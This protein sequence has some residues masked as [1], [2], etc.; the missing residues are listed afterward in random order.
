MED[1]F[2]AASDKIHRIWE[3]SLTGLYLR[4]IGA[5]VVGLFSIMLLNF[6]TP[7]HLLVLH[8]NFILREGG[9]VLLV[10]IEPIVMGI[11]ILFQY[12]IQRPVVEVIKA[13]GR[14]EEV[15]EQNLSRVRRRILNLPFIFWFFNLAL[16]IVLSLILLSLFALLL[17]A[18]AKQTLLL[19]FRT[20]MIG[21]IAANLSFFLVEDHTRRILIPVF[22]PKG[23]LHQVPGILRISILRR[24]RMLYM[25]GTSVPMIILLGTLFFTIWD[26]GDSSNARL[27]GREILVF[28]FVLCA[29]FFI[30]A[31][32]LN[33]LVERSILEPLKA[34]LGIIENLESGDFNQKIRVTS[35]DEIGILGD[36]GNRMISGLA[37]RERIRETFGKYVTPEIRD[38]ILDGRIPLDGER[39]EATLLFSDLRD[40]TTY[41]EENA[42]EEVIRSMREYFTAMQKAIR[43]HQGLVLQ[44]VGDEIEAAFGIPIHISDHAE[45]ALRAAIA[46]RKSLE[47]LNG[48]RE[49]Q[50]K[51]PFKHGIGIYTG[52]V[53][54][55]NTGSKDRL[56]YAL[57]GNTVNLAS[58][59]QGLTKDLQWD[60]LVS[61]ETVEKLR[62]PFSL[63]RESPR[64]IKGYSMPVTVYRVL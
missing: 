13:F 16:W 32:R 34:M 33:L 11:T 44:Y 24:I 7:S 2:K 14:G 4:N 15:P 57:I 18:P 56:S 26:I 42:P 29:I 12:K 31:L 27:L 5:N 28:S 1:K 3:I 6:F 30:I 25:A 17:N 55:G 60:I 61:E 47:K 49:R 9:W 51:I 58:R 41:V 22:F 10:V 38:R 21:I 35:S 46:M 8:Q 62:Q 63:H 50:G 37:E 43:K 48:E 23:R 45:N 40:F 20:I 53:L 36:A 19:L 39:S 59:I 64:R 54:A 52:T